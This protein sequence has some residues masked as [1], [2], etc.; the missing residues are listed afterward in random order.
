MQ[1]TDEDALRRAEAVRQF[2]RFYLKHLGA[3]HARLPRSEFSLTEIRIL[4]ELSRGHAQTAAALARDLSLDTGYLSRILAGF[5]KRNLISRRPSATDARQ[6]LLALTDDGHAHFA[7]LDAAVIGSVHASL[8]PLAPTEQE[9]LVAAMRIVERLLRRRKAEG[10]V[11]LRAPRAGEYGW[12]VYRQAQWFANEYGWGPHFEAALAESVAVFAQKQGAARET[13]WIAEQDGNA[14]GSAFVVAAGHSVAR[15]RLL[16]V[17]P[18]VRRLGIGSQLLDECVR[19][20]ERAGYEMLDLTLTDSLGDAK[21]L[22]G[23]RGFRY[24]HSAREER[25]GRELIVERWVRELTPT[26]H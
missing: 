1:S 10:N 14:V 18:Y 24:E 22:A 15:V 4:Y 25:F 9:E 8:A 19:F 3:L 16:F 13:G 5:E 23:R 26:Q 7:P 12:L 17:E 6:S 2:N 20:A 11:A 21:R